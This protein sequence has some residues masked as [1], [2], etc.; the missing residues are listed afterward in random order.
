MNRRLIAVLA[1]A[2]AVLPIVLAACGS[3]RSSEPAATHVMPDGRTMSGSAMPGMA[4]SMGSDG[5]GAGPSSAAAM[6]CGSETR[7]AVRRTLG[8]DRAPVGLHAWQPPL[9]TCTYQ[10]RSGALRLSVRDLAAAAA[11]RESFA[12]LRTRLP[13]A[14]RIR[15]VES[16]GF[17]AFE[18]ARG[19]VVFLK[20]HKTLWVDASR[21]GSS[22]LPA[23][24]SR[25]DVA[26]G[27]AAAVIACWSE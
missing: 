1:A 13:G 6:I 23:G 25:Q 17:P 26:Y 9:F 14:T 12:R 2:A 21:L 8:L 4:P 27:V 10:L 3:S 19:D 22:A 24:T 7:D 18:T 20:D 5:S 15:G 16:F 11:G